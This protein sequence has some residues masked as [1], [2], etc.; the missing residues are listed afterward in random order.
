M[1]VPKR[2]TKN[3]FATALQPETDGRRAE[4]TR[5]AKEVLIGKLRDRCAVSGY[6]LESR[7][8][9]LNREDDRFTLHV[10]D[11]KDLVEVPLSW[12]NVAELRRT[13][14]AVASGIEWLGDRSAFAEMGQGYIEAAIRAVRPEVDLPSWV[15]AYTYRVDPDLFPDVT[16]KPDSARR[17]QPFTTPNQGRMTA[18]NDR[19]GIFVEI[20]APSIMAEVLQHRLHGPFLRSSAWAGQAY[21]ATIKIWRPAGIRDRDHAVAL[22]DKVTRSTSYELDVSFSAGFELCERPV[23]PPDS[24][25]LVNEPKNERMSV[26]Q[27]LTLTLNEYSQ[28]GLSYYWHAR[29]SESIPVMEYLNYYQVLEY[30]FAQYALARTLEFARQKLKDPRFDPANSESLTRFVN[31]IGDQ[32]KSKGTDFPGLLATLEHCIDV[33]QLADFIESDDDLRSHLT[34]KTI[35][36]VPQV[37]TAQRDQLVE[38][39]ARRIHGIRNTLV[40]AKGENRNEGSFILVPGS[41]EMRHLVQE[42]KLARFAAQSVLIASSVSAK[43]SRDFD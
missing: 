9:G 15:A 30:H 38:R 11:G 42:I 22:L 8:G 4:A 39:M 35:P 18:R 27:P 34:K 40:H 25:D 26:H 2:K 17:F 28:D 36:G 23:W 16:T 10:P 33:D 20:S 1:P 37:V 41:A 32:V 21:F 29:Q 6:R 3:R 5:I 13:V 14:Q 31:A 43:H 12:S 19:L 7:K 24:Y